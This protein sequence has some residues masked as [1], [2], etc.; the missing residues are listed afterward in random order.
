MA[1]IGWKLERMIDRDT[2]GSSIAAMLT[3]VAV[4]SGPWLLTT[5]LLVLMRISAVASG[6][7]EVTSAERVITIVYAVA[8]VVSAPI[9]IVLTRFSADCVYERRCERIAAPLCRALA[10]ILVTFTGIG[11][12]AMHFA[13]VGLSLAIPGA[14]LAAIVGAQWLLLSA[15][16]GLSSPG[17]ILRAFAAGAPVSALA[18]LAIVSPLELGPVGYLLGFGAGQLVTLGVLLHG[19]LRALPEKQD[20]SASLVEAGREYITL[21]IAAFAFN[22]GLWIDKLVVLLIGGADLA[23]QYAALA[24][25]AWLSIVPACAYLFVVVETSFHRRFHGFYSALHHGSSL[26]DLRTRVGALRGQVNRTLSQTSSVQACVTLV[27]LLAGP[28]I[29]GWL[30]LDGAPAATI[31]WLVLGAGLQVVSFA[32]ILLLY[33]FD[34]RAEALIASL[35]QLLTN[36]VFT[37]GVGISATLGAGY[38][39]SCAVTAVVSVVLLRARLPGLLPRTFQSQPDLTET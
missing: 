38:A 26:S 34:Y 35:T 22:A 4:T 18:W 12:I 32:A 19:I 21:A 13:N 2:F 30:K 33:Y 5:A 28:A 16:G 39:A 1:G 36:A 17:I 24:A 37:L 8:I 20:E 6:I 29:V 10:T 31:L 25:V 15:A 11:A 3:G 27:C 23:S 9:D 7:T 14:I